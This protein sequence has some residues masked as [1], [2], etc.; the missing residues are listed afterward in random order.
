MSGHTAA[1]PTAFYPLVCPVTGLLHGCRCGRCRPDLHLAV[2]ST[3]A[4]AVR[5]F[6]VS[7]VTT[8]ADV[9][10]RIIYGDG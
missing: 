6:W 7:A 1:L 10:T 9:A 8:V 3:A 5:T 4:N 2:L